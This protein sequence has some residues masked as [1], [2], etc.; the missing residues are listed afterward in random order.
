M[1]YGEGYQCISDCF[2]GALKTGWNL[3]SLW[4]DYRDDMVNGDIKFSREPYNGFILDPYFTKLDLSDCSYI[5]RRK[6]LD[7]KHTASLLPGYEREIYDLHE[8]GWEKDDKF[9]WL[10]Y[11]RMPS[12]PKLMAYDELYQQKWKQVPMLVDMES[13]ETIEFDLDRET[14]KSFLEQ[15]PQL[16]VVKRPKKY[17]E[18]NIIVNGE[19]IKTEINPYDLDEYPFVPFTAIFEPESDDWSLKVQS[20]IRCMVDPQRESNR[21][22]SQMVDML[23]S[24]VNSGWIANENSVIN[25]RSLFQSSQGK[26]IWKREDA[27]PGSIEKIPPAQ[28]PPSMFQLQQLFDNDVVEISG[29][30]DAA[31]GQTENAGE[32]GVM[33]LLRQGAALINLQDLFDNLRLSQKTISKKILKL[34]QNWKPAKVKRILNE[35]PT[36]E[37]YDPKITKYDVSI[38][39]GVLTDTQKQMYF[40]QLVDLRQLGAPV[41]GEMLAQAAP[42]QGKTEYIR[43]ISEMEQQQA[44]Q[45]QEQQQ[46]QAEL[47]KSQKQM[48]E[49]K[50]ISDIALSKERFTRAVANMGLQEERNSEAIQ[51]RSQASLD[52]AKTIKE[53][54]SLDDARLLKYLQIAL[55]LDEMNKRE[56]EKHKVEDIAVTEQSEKLNAAYPQPQGMP[57]T[58]GLMSSTLGENQPPG[59]F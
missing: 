44:Q 23:D 40:R 35:E 56:E 7:V 30:N 49:A 6:Y 41:T 11:Q 33:M 53:L 47:I 10:P 27:P 19:Y 43:Q 59:M 58:P 51:N 12:G 18:L 20:L 9:T 28:I 57:N 13:G 52:R 15:Y 36:Q 39:E 4:V 42:I 29:V 32:S 55:Q 3:L 50:A 37:F 48:S 24:Q 34:I 16:K 17:I 8:K 25:P 38:Q 21:R 46:I 22:R 14:I 31:F 54:E 45:A 2:G 5:L 1:N 26:V